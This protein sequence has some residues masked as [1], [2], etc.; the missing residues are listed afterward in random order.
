MHLHM[1]RMPKGFNRPVKPCKYPKFSRVRKFF[2]D[3]RTAMKIVFC[4]HSLVQA[5]VVLVD[6]EFLH[7]AC[8]YW[9]MVVTNWSS[10]FH[11]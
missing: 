2:C 5:E 11:V 1:I 10:L 9:H 4:G 8:I 6:D 3:C 7:P